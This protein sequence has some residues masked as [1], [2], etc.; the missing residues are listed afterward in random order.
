MK[1]IEAAYWFLAGASAF[2]ALTHL[3]FWASGALPIDFK[4]FTVG[5]ALNQVELWGS[6]ALAILF[7]LL[8]NR[9]RKK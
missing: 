5:N 2:H 1:H 7:M 3:F 6:I 8:A 4:I 9:V